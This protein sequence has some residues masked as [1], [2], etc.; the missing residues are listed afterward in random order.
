LLTSAASRTTF[1]VRSTFFTSLQSI[2]GIFLVFTM[3]TA[4]SDWSTATLP[5]LDF[6][7]GL[8]REKEFFMEVEYFREEGWQNLQIHTM[9]K[10]LLKTAH[11][12]T[13]M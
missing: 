13:I 8:K 4:D 12:G 6:T 9:L 7:E 11:V 5:I 10:T 3:I 2:P 1:A